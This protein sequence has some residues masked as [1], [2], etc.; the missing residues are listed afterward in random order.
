MFSDL[1]GNEADNDVASRYR[2]SPGAYKRSALGVLSR[3]K[4][5]VSYRIVCCFSSNRSTSA[6]KDE[7][8]IVTRWIIRIPV[9]AIIDL[10]KHLR[11]CVDVL[12]LSLGYSG[13]PRVEGVLDAPLVNPLNHDGCASLSNVVGYVASNHAPI[14]PPYDICIDGGGHSHIERYSVD[15]NFSRRLCAARAIPFCR[16]QIG[17]KTKVKKGVKESGVE[18][19]RIERSPLPDPPEGTREARWRADGSPKR[20]TTSASC[21]VRSSGGDLLVEGIS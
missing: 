18:G 2:Q 16:C 3:I 21:N 11:R 1:I 8:Q 7:A 6:Y 13:R 12:G 15:N 14:Q 9:Q 20:T 4:Y 17:P 5:G 19:L 10:G